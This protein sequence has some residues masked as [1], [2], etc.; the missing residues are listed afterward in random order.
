[1]IDAGGTPQPLV[2]TVYLLYVT[3]LQTGRVRI[4]DLTVEH[5]ESVHDGIEIYVGDFFFQEQPNAKTNTETSDASCHGRSLIV[6]EAP[7]P[8]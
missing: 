3:G 5:S 1:V 6:V 2:G 8:H 4:V 7:R